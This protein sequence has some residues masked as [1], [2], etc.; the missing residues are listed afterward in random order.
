MAFF[1]ARLRF[2]GGEEVFAGGAD[3]TI[4]GCVSGFTE[5]AALEA[6]E[7][8]PLDAAAVM[9]TRDLFVVVELL[10]GH[11]KTLKT[12]SLTHFELKAI[13]AFSCPCS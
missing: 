6:A 5:A 11:G 10:V 12:R 8:L 4:D 3:D 13:A 9:V 7:V 1:V 2:L